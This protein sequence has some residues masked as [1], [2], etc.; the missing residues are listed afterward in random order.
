MK[1]KNCISTTN[2]ISKYKQFL[3]QEIHCT[4]QNG[5]LSPSVMEWYSKRNNFLIELERSDLLL[6]GPLHSRAHISAIEGTSGRYLRRFEMRRNQRNL[7]N[8]RE[9]NEEGESKKKIEKYDNGK[10]SKLDV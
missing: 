4:F 5:F 3:T 7:K 2:P 6:V 9:G 10:K 1:E 8:R